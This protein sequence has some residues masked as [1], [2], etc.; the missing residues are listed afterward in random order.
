MSLFS[1]LWISSGLS[2]LDKSRLIFIAGKLLFRGTPLNS[3]YINTS[4]SAVNLVC[5]V[6]W[7]F[8]LTCKLIAWHRILCWS[9]HS[10]SLYVLNYTC[11]I[12][13]ANLAY[14]AI[15]LFGSCLLLTFF[16]ISSS[17]L[18]LRRYWCLLCSFNSLLNSRRVIWAAT[19]SVCIWAANFIIEAQ[20]MAHA[21]FYLGLSD[22]WHIL[23]LIRPKL[24][25]L[26][27]FSTCH[28][29]GTRNYKLIVL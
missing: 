20:N 14:W 21:L 23:Q 9:N 4:F 17:V 15:L 5:F 7:G 16:T 2:W 1:W 24:L 19:L 29:N 11:G 28:H 27:H 8:N 13:R 22:S 12:S 26:A 3:A 25:K 18:F 6:A 10:L